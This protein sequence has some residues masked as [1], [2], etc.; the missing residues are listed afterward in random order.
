MKEELREKL[1]LLNSKMLDSSLSD[2]EFITLAHIIRDYYLKEDVKKS[3][4]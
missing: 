3:Y 4:N 2:S 1:I